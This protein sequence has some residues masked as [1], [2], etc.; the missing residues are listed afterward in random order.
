M[1]GNLPRNP[2]EAARTPD[3]GWQV[4]HVTVLKTGTGQPVETVPKS[5]APADDPWQRYGNQ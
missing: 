3:A 2:E 1:Q 4:N 5:T